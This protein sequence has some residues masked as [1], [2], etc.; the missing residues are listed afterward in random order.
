MCS[1]DLRVFHGSGVKPGDLVVSHIGRYIRAGG[2]FL[3]YDSYAVDRD[4]VFPEPFKI[5]LIIFP[6]CCK[7][8]R[9]LLKKAERIGYVAGSASE[10]FCQAVYIEADIQD[11]YLVRKNVVR[12]PSGKVHNPVIG[13]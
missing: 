9:L 1:S 5:V 11:V 12:K 4:I 3:R 10:F 7:D 6:D 2:K 8:E 13:H